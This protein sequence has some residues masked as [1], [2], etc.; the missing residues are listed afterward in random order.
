MLVIALV[1]A[2]VLQCFAVAIGYFAWLLRFLSSCAVVRLFWVFTASLNMRNTEVV[3][4]LRVTDWKVSK[5]PMATNPQHLQELFTLFIICLR[6]LYG[7]SAVFVDVVWERTCLHT[8]KLLFNTIYQSFSFCFLPFSTSRANVPLFISSSLALC[9][10]VCVCACACVLCVCVCCVRVR[11][12]VCECVVCV[13]VCVRVCVCVCARARVCVC[14][15]VCL[16]DFWMQRQCRKQ[17]PWWH[18]HHSVPAHI[19]K[20][21]SF[22]TKERENSKN[23]REEY[24]RAWHICTISTDKVRRRRE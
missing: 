11:V 15:G 5:R 9:V 4:F 23:V 1:A 19:W 21:S 24:K 16:S 20:C 3:L 8:L 12:C 2:E 22:R 10:C 7:S 18:H 6:C 13:C 14:V 17:S